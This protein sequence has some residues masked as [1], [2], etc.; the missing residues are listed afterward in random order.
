M[1]CRRVCG[2]VE[3]GVVGVGGVVVMFELVLELELE[4]EPRSAFEERI[5]WSECVCVVWC[6]VM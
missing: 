2:R 1:T 3:V 4:L 5:V 6:G